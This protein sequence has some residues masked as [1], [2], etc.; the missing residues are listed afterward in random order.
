MTLKKLKL[1][2]NKPLSNDEMKQ[3]CGGYSYDNEDTETA[4]IHPYR[5][6]CGMGSDAIFF[7]LN[8]PNIDSAMYTMEIICSHHSDGLGGCFA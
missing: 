5:C 1:K 6:G 7:T 8:R 4:P 3:I 2:V